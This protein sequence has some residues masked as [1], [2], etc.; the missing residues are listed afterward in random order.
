MKS[1]IK[2]FTTVLHEAGQYCGV[3]TA[4]DEISVARRLSKEGESFLTI[5]LPAYE[6]DLLRALDAGRITSDLFSGFQKSGGFPVLFSGFLRKIFDKKG[7]IRD[8]S[9]E[10][11]QALR[12]IRQVLLFLSKIELVSSDARVEKAFDSYV[13]TDSELAQTNELLSGPYRAALY[14]LQE[15]FDAVFG[16]YLSDVEADLVKDPFFRGNH[17]PGAVADHTGNNARWSNHTWT[18]RLE[19]VLPVEST[20]ACNIHDYMDNNFA[21]L[22]EAQEPPVRVV[23][24]PK[25]MKGPRVIAIEP[26]HMQYVQQGLFALMTRTLT[27]PAHRRLNS[28]MGWT[29]QVPNRMLSRDW[30]RYATIDLSEASDRVSLLLVE[31]LFEKYPLL[32]DAIL[33]SRSQRAELPGGKVITLNKFASMGSAM[34]FPVE[35]MVFTACAVAS[36]VWSDESMIHRWSPLHL[37]NDASLEVPFRIFGDDMV[38][39]IDWTPNLLGILSLFGLK[40]NASK[41]FWTGKFRESCGADWYDGHDV[42]VVKIRSTINLDRQDVNSIVR[43]I[44]LHNRFFETGWFK[45]AAA[46]EDILKNVRPMLY[47]P[48]GSAV[49]ALWTYDSTKCVFNTHKQYQR[50]SVQAFSLKY[51]Y[52][53]DPLDGYGALRKYFAKSDDVATPWDYDILRRVADP[54]DAEHLLHAGRPVHVA[55]TVRN[56]AL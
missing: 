18:E 35:S 30:G 3:N 29:D 39:P 49:L 25:T 40:V 24:V 36:R 32:R 20:L 37:S 7:V 45:S 13:N 33:A 16:P 51:K 34:C 21:W 6:K 11:V 48:Y 56:V 17:G 23:S 5:S 28:V 31:T 4:R 47:A 27:K 44:S 42:S 46:V 2:L 50:I 10:L 12:S 15:A 43:G 54:S 19:A 52:K 26:M 38:V 9:A 55:M 8:T 22:T 41:S 1:H 14:G 53:S